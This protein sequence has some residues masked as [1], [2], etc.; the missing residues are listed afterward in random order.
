MSSVRGSA[1]ASHARI[2]RSGEAREKKKPTVRFPYNEFVLTTGF[3]NVVELSKIYSQLR[4]LCKFD[5]SGDWFR[6]RIAKAVLGVV[7]VYNVVFSERSTMSG[8]KWQYADKACS[9]FSKSLEK[10]EPSASDNCRMCSCC[11][12]TQFGNFNTGWISSENMSVAPT[13]TRKTSNVTKIGRP[14]D[15]RTFC[16]PRRRRIFL[17]KGENCAAI[18]SQLNTPTDTGIHQGREHHKWLV[19]NITWQFTK[20]LHQNL[21]NGDCPWLEEAVNS[22]EYILFKTDSPY[23]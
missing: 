8:R 23:I 13:S 1:W 22:N 7:S 14:S 2:H 19:A 18:L 4:P 21:A 17:H 20:S 5:T 12:K 11:F 15:K 10:A 3:K 9:C 16:C 6:E